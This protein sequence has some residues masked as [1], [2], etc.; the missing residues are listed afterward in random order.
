[1]QSRKLFLR[2]GFNMNVI[3]TFKDKRR[4][5]QITYERKMLRELSLEG[6]RNTVNHHFGNYFKTG[7]LFSSAIE[8]GCLDIAI[9]S[10][11]L[12]AKLSR[13]GHFGE[14][15]EEVKKRSYPDEKYLIDTLYEFL[16]Y[17][18]QIG[19]SDFISESLYYTC[20]HYVEHWWTEGF[21]KGEK[22]YRLRLH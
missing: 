21:R 1:M 17:W 15:M 11:L 4:E 3:T 9:E 13:F 20:V 10:Y 7:T 19:E 12:G 5:K 22:R 14:S 2:G 18:G 8:E 6:L 16:T